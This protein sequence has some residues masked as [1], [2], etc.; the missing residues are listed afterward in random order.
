MGYEDPMMDEKECGC[1]TEIE[2]SD[3][4]IIFCPLHEAAPKLLKALEKIARG[5]GRFNRDQ[6]THCENTVE[7]MKALAVAAIEEAGRTS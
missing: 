7:D 6:L 5:E 3:V 1:R 4:H 2:G